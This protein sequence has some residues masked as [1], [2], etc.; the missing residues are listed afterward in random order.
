MK[1]TSCA[2]NHNSRFGSRG[3]TLIELLVVIAIIAILAAMLLPALSRAKSKAQGIH[4]MNNH[5]QLAF[6]WRMYAEDS[7]DVLTYASTSTGAS[8]P[9]GGSSNWP[10]D[11]AWSGA[12]MDDDGGNRAN[13]DP[14]YDMMRRPLWPYAKNQALYKC[15]SDRSVVRTASGI[16]PRILTMSMNLYVGGFAPQVGRD[17]LPNGTAGG[18]SFADGYMIY[19]KL[20]TIKVPAK[21]FV[22][23]DM[24][25]DRVNWSN[26]MA[27]MSGYYPH[28]PSLYQLGDL[29]G[30]YHGL[31]AGFS[32]AD[33]HAEIKRWRDSRT[34]PPLGPIM[35]H[36]PS[37]ST[38][39]NVDVAWLQEV[40]TERK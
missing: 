8:A 5:R 7:R 14:A 15:P 30:M 16:R 21:I 12:H 36:A 26:F 20:A 37:F 1:R 11:F 22:F 10:D 13:W 38:P 40:S 29:P 23:L 24:R 25:E 28:N 35:P 27:I 34:T 17:P 2:L 39:G 4:C 6:A 9:P 32:F 31:A 18:W 19:P 33:G 3:F